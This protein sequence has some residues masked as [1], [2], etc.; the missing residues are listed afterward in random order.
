MIEKGRVVD[1]A[2]GGEGVVRLADGRRVLVAGVLSDEQVLIKYDRKEHAK[3]NRTLRA[4]LVKIIEAS[5][6][7]REAP[8]VYAS[9]CGG[10]ALMHASDEAQLTIKTGWVSALLGRAPDAVHRSPMMLGYRGR[11]RLAWNAA[12]AKKRRAAVLGFRR[13]A[14][15]DL[16]GIEQ[17]VVLTDALNQVLR[18]LRDDVLKHLAGQGHM[19]LSE[20][21][22]PTG[23]V[24]VQMISG[25]AQPEALYRTLDGLVGTCGVRGVSCVFGGATQVHRIGQ[26]DDV[27]HAS[28]HSDAIEGFVQGNRALNPRLV[29]RVVALSEVRDRKV[30]EFYSGSG[31]FSVALAAGAKQLEGFELDKNAVA[32]ANALLAAS[33]RAHAKVTVRDLASEVAPAFGE[34]VVLDPPRSGAQQVVA[35]IRD[36]SAKPMRIVYVSCYPTTLKRDL[37]VLADSY[38]L[39][40]LEL[41]DMFAQTG[42]VEV[43]ACLERRA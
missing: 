11:A 16:V 33:G 12:D 4:K 9:T 27:G 22:G 30:S 14:T 29:E 6:D 5:A 7:R 1:V 31:N 28:E 15:H 17:C 26:I 24:A 36:A 40:R 37:A 19:V 32:R 18:I 23:G 38:V 34:V 2:F 39:S 10:C 41:F 3:K 8:C 13:G 20:L 43:V 35:A 25:D 21:D 42:H